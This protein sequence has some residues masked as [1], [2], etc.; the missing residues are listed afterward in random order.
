MININY[1][2][3]IVG[4]ST[5]TKP[6]AQVENG[7][8][9]YTVDTQELYIYYAGDWYLQTPIETTPSEDDT[10]P[11]EDTREEIK[12]PIVEREEIIENPVER[13]IIDEPIIENPFV[14]EPKEDEAGDR[15]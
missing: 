4:L 7:S 9:F 15:K 3:D 11:A 8:T 13:E 1:R 2:I 12:E 14:D 5:D 6:T 10:T